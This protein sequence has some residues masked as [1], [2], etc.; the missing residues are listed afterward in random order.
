MKIGFTVTI[1]FVSLL[2]STSA[3]AQ[4]VTQSSVI[5]S[6]TMACTLN[7]G[8]TMAD[9]VETARSFPWSEDVAPAVVLMRN[10][11]AASGGGGNFGPE[12]DFLVTS[13]Y[14]S[15]AD[16]VEKRGNFLR[17]QAGRNG[18]RGIAPFATCSDNI[19]ISSVRFAT[20][21]TGAAITPATAA[22]TAFCELNGGTVSD[23][24]ALASGFEENWAS[25]ATALVS[26]RSFG[27]PRRP[28]NSSVGIMLSFES[29]PE[30]GAAWDRLQQNPGAPN[31]ENPVSCT[32]PSLWAQYLIHQGATN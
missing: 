17:S 28:I 2:G 16:M 22:A 3:F 6:R 11:I 25:G 32:T 24:V 23:A 10:K 8:Y 9:V 5:A 31:P 30:F 21:P 1:L 14:P 26:S 20:P 13:Y 27:G 12:F 4:P 7:P 29:F 18:L 19:V 15:Y